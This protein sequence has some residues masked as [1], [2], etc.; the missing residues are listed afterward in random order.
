MK[1]PEHW[2]WQHHSRHIQQ[3][4]ENAN[5]EIKSLLVPTSALDSFIPIVGERST[6]QTTS[7]DDRNE[8]N[9]IDAQDY[10]AC[11]AK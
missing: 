6:Y 3:E 10:V 4:V 5:E 2:H 9:Q 11:D 8:V 1:T 7:E